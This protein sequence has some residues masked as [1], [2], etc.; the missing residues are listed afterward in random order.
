MG[1]W[2]DGFMDRLAAVHEQNLE[3][4]GQDR[5][6]LQHSLGKLTARERIDLLVDEGSFM[7]MGALVRDFREA[8]GK[9][10]KPT[11][12]D[13]VVMGAAE[14]AGR[15]VMVYA[16]DFTV[17]SG[18]LGDQ[19]AWKIAELVDMAGKEQVPII[20]MFDGAGSRMSLKNG[21]IGLYGYAR[22]IRNYCLYSGVIP[23]ISLVLGPCTGP[24]A[25]IPVLSDFTIMNEN[26]GFMWLGGERK[27]EDAGNADFHMEESGQVDLLAGS[28]E[29][30]MELTR[31]LLEFMPQNCW[32]KP[33]TIASDDDPDRR[34]EE[35][36]TIMPDNPKFTYDMHEVIELIVDNGEFFEIKEDFAPNLIAGF[37]RFDGMP[38][39]IVASNPDELSGIMEPDSSDKYDRFMMFLDTFNIPLINIS[40][41]TAYPPGDKWERRG[42]IRHG[43]KNLHGYANVTTAKITLVLRRSYGGSNITMGCSKM[44]PDFIFAWPTAEFAPTG[45][46]SIVL[47]VFHKQLAKAKEEGNYDE[48]YDFLLSTLREQFSVMTFGKAYTHYYTVNEVI[49]PRDTRKRIVKALKAS[50]SKRELTPKKRRAIKPA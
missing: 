14:I 32:E 37:A 34:E 30:A 39:G 40:D 28:D 47:A 31:R 6:D 36:L 16:L 26:T 19:G 11:P 45:P 24:M 7:E 10:S 17:L 23:Q 8:S 48:V 15:Q 44:G 50:A 35:L 41:T 42:V 2:M 27:S 1:K 38:V 21:A 13:G 46:E 4:G 9:I 18:A 3:G 29:E 49:D 20:G 43:A 25:Q 12:A 22:L 5:I 33:L